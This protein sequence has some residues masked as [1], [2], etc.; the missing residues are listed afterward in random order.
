[1]I[2]IGI[3]TARPTGPQSHPMNRAPKSTVT[4]S[5]RTAPP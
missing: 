5:N 2:I 4:G 1:M 3:D